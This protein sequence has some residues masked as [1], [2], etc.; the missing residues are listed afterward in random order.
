MASQ[1]PKLRV[2][3]GVSGGGRSLE[4]LLDRQGKEFFEIVGVISSRPD[5]RGV[6][7]AKSAHLPVLVCEFS[8]ARRSPKLVAEVEDFAAVQRAN[9]VALAGFLKPYPVSRTWERRVINIHPALLPRHGGKGMYG[10]KV[11]E[12][13]LA[14]RDSRSGATVHYVSDRYDE[15]PIIAQ[16]SVLT[17]GIRDS[18][19]LAARV[20]EAECDLYP[21]VL[22]GLA[23]GS[24]P[25]PH[26]DV[27]KYE[28]GNTPR[29][30]LN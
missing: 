16:A 11:H 15:G 19:A 29:A 12:A 7:I 27:L 20:F 22:S 10:M 9:L 18:A 6:D 14:A 23:C 25:L 21:R 8:P 2:L 5:C 28:F 13:V 26:G 30:S 4:N 3:V 1:Q 24:L 17:D